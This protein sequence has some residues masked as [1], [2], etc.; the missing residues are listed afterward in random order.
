MVNTMGYLV[1]FKY[2]QYLIQH[3][4]IARIRCGAFHDKITILRIYHPELKK[5][6]RRVEK[7]E[8]TWF[9]KLYDVVA[10]GKSGDTTIYY[11]LHDKK[12]EDLLAD[13]ALYLRRNG[14][15]SRRDHSILAMLY[16][17]ITQALIQQPSLAGQGQGTE[18]HFPVSNQ[19]IFPVYPVHFAPP[20]ELV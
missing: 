3:E 18:F 16:N 20:P 12:E 19:I 6:F 9:G 7:T 15:T 13:Y 11:C 5:Q 4:M 17:L 14:D 2:N 1:I 10:E 8:F